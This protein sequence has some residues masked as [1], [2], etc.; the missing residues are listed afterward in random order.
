MCLKL[1]QNKASDAKMNSSRMNCMNLP[2]YQHSAC[3]DGRFVYVT[4]SKS[5]G[6]N[7]FKINGKKKK[8]KKTNL[9]DAVLSDLI[10]LITFG[11]CCLACNKKGHFIQVAYLVQL[12]TS[13][14]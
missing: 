2:R 10:Q 14:L 9:L 5:L 4:G 3:T 7:N 6:K 11:S 1:S 12:F 8:Q 13:Y